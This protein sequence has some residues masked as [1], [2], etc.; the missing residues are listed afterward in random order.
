MT[1]EER[2][3][4]KR[5]EAEIDSMLPT[6]EQRLT[7]WE[8]AWRDGA[9]PQRPLLV[10]PA[11]LQWA[12]EIPPLVIPEHIEHAHHAADGMTREQYVA[13]HDGPRARLLRWHKGAC[14]LC[15]NVMPLME[16]HDHDTGLVRGYLCGSCNTREGFAGD[17][18]PF[19]VYRAFPPTRMLGLEIRYINPI[20]G[21]PDY[22][23]PRR[24][25]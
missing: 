12:P 10:V 17:I 18:M 23:N 5:R 9:V 11:Y 16:D 6:P 7:R 3:E 21:E 15:W 1:D 24:T 13:L 8:E 2:A 25:R 22:G 20:T 14:A 4:H 19:A